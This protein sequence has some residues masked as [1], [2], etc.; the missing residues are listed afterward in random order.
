MNFDYTAKR[1]GSKQRPY[2]KKV[3]L[4]PKCGQRGTS[5][6]ICVTHTGRLV[7]VADLLMFHA[8]EWCTLPRKETT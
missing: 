7:I 3:I 6:G 8:D 1:I 4:C 5:D 2:N